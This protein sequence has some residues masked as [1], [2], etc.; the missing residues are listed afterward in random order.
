MQYRR[1]E[2]L[3]GRAEAGYDNPIGELEYFRETGLLKLYALKERNEAKQAP[4]SDDLYLFF[5]QII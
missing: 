3:T 5:G 2:L 4:L 1:K